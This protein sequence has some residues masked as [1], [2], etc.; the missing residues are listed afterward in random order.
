MLDA[1]SGRYADRR[2][3]L[4]RTMQLPDELPPETRFSTVDIEPTRFVAEHRV[5]CPDHLGG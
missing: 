1:S 4:R 5:T 2:D 3:E